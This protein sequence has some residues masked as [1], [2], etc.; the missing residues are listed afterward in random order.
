MYSNTRVGG[1]DDRRNE[2]VWR[3]QAR[4]EAD[5]NQDQMYIR[6]EPRVGMA[7]GRMGGR[8]QK[9]E[10]ENAKKGK[11]LTVNAETNRDK[12]K[13]DA[14]H[15]QREMGGKKMGKILSKKN[16]ERRRCKTHGTAKHSWENTEVG[17]LNVDAEE[18][19]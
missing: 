3:A 4:R 10:S 9:L 6:N 17:S 7:K 19:V 18:G 8:V 5:P 16:L 1:G 14:G 13:N 2:R 11:R 15:F 12:G